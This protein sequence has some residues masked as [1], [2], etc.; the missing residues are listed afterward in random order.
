[1]SKI[2]SKD[3]GPNVAS[4]VNCAIVALA[5]VGHQHCQKVDPN[6]RQLYFRNSSGGVLYKMDRSETAHQ[7][8]TFIEP[9]ATGVMCAT[10]T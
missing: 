2:L 1:V 4:T 3:E 7:R 8:D 9:H 5:E 6:A 10:A